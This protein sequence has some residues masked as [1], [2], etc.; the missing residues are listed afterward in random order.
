MCS[1][2]FFIN[3]NKSFTGEVLPPVFILLLHL[4]DN[5]LRPV[6]VLYFEVATLEHLFT[7]F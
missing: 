5:G 1:E 2:D 3:I 7:H 4:G 6:N